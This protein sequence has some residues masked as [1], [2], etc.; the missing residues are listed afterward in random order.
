[1]VVADGGEDDWSSSGWRRRWGEVR[2]VGGIFVNKTLLTHHWYTLATCADHSDHLFHSHD[3]VFSGFSV[4]ISP[5]CAD[6]LAIMH[7]LTTIP[8]GLP[9]S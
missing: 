7:I 3:I 8:L 5:A 4:L 1:M 6:S 2:N 9:M